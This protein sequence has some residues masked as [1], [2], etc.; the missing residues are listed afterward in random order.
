MY[1]IVGGVKNYIFTINYNNILYSWGEGILLYLLVVKR[2]NVQN[3]YNII[4]W[5][6]TTHDINIIIIIIMVKY[7]I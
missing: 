6:I 4:I 7:Y 5:D 1:N 3:T 2:Q